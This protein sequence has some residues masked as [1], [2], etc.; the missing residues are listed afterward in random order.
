[1][2]FSNGDYPKAEERKWNILRERASK[3]YQ[4]DF[5][6]DC[7]AFCDERH[8]GGVI[9][10]ET[11]RNCFEIPSSGVDV[12]NSYYK[13]CY[14]PII[15]DNAFNNDVEDK[16]GRFCANNGK[17]VFTYRNGKTYVAKGY[18]IISELRNAGYIESGLFVPF[19]NGETILDPILKERWESIGK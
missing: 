15:K 14:P 12:K 16:L 11:L 5:E 3:A 9:S 18:K 4:D 1:M 8:I 10:D 13:T 7:A 17:V 2:P 6:Q 19:S